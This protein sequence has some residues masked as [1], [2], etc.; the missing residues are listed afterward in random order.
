MKYR[1]SNSFAKSY[2]GK[3]WVTDRSDWKKANHFADCFNDQANCTAHS[4]SYDGFFSDVMVKVICSQKCRACWESQC[5]AGKTQN[6]MFSK[7]WS[8]KRRQDEISRLEIY[9][10]P[11]S[12]HQPPPSLPKT[13]NSLILTASSTP[14]DSTSLK[15]AYV[16]RDCSTAWHVA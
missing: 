14:R 9:F 12:S 15:L 2:V 3:I 7:T 13:E 4:P 11:N 1:V 6:R 5:S 10:V 8:S 16:R